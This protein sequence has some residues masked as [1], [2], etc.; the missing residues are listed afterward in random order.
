MRYWVYQDARISGPLELKEL[1][2]G[3]LRAD[4]LVCE[5][6]VGGGKDQDWRRAEEV[7]ELSGLYVTRQPAVSVVDLLGE[8]DSLLEQ[9]RFEPLGLETA[10]QEDWLSGVFASKPLKAGL[11]DMAAE[12]TA[13]QQRVRE[14]TEKLESLTR[15]MEQSAA[16]P[17]SQPPAA[18][19]PP[20]A[21]V[22]PASAGLPEVSTPQAALPAA[23]FPQASPV[24][25]PE[26]SASP[27]AAPQPEESDAD[28]RLLRLP[29]PAPRRRI[30]LGAP[31]S[32]PSV[33]KEAPPASAQIKTE[34]VEP[35]KP[36][37][38]D[39]S[40]PSAPASEQAGSGRH[41]LKLPAQAA[42][43]EVKLG[44]PKKFASVRKAA[45]APAPVQ[46]PPQPVSPEAVSQRAEPA[47][48]AAPAPVAPPP[49][50]P[51]PS[52]PESTVMPAPTPL[53]QPPAAAAAELPP[54]PVLQ[55]QLGAA[56]QGLEP[57]PMP[58]LPKTP[59]PSVTPP[60]ATMAYSGFFSAPAPAVSAEPVAAAEKPAAT[61]QVL[62]RLAKPQ[63]AAAPAQDKPRGGDKKFLIISGTLVVAL[64]AAGFLFLQNSKSIPSAV[65]M[66]GDQTLLGAAVEEPAPAEV[67]AAA[68]PAADSALIA[69][70]PEAASPPAQEIPAAPPASILETAPPAAAVAPLPAA[71]AP[72]VA[73]VKDDREA[74]IE[75]VKEF[76]IDGDRGTI[77]RWLEYSFAASPGFNEKWDA[78]AVE[79][80][81][82]LVQY[83]VQD[84]GTG[85]NLSPAVTYL[86]EADLERHIVQG[87]NQAA[88]QLLAGGQV[89]AQKTQLK[90]SRKSRPRRVA[91]KP[92]AALPQQLPQLPLPS[93]TELLPPGEEGENR[94]NAVE[95]GF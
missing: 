8:D 13:S 60:P 9:L 14:L 78:G 73:A 30:S 5:E 81:A 63:P 27:A 20:P 37:V 40:A 55:P 16:P 39:P 33:K 44:A 88:R 69:A 32:F 21:A 26:P 45:E 42:S 94:S 1:E 61:E 57:P 59:I 72:V 89:P 25:A 22:T 29:A 47:A 48:A 2:G 50:A 17:V 95:S 6:S 62:A 86:F 74:A 56:P 19:A 38:S 18:I 41:L 24:P 51:V 28:R 11:Q 67:P 66:G 79:G 76:P 71:Q 53:P 93:E 10:P 34:P 3:H 7:P 87:K 58:V 80:A 90:N 91:S 23:P 75:L 15:R 49:P 54:M 77:G 12:L 92:S 68:P 52:A 83:T 84:A 85:K 65:D 70:G 36:A 4:A 35:P 43:K 64:V 31:K 82:Y 46:P